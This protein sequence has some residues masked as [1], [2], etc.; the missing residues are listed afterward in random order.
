MLT[1]FHEL[2]G[3]WYAEKTQDGP[4]WINSFVI[5]PTIKKLG[6]GRIELKGFRLSG[7]ASDHIDYTPEQ[8]VYF[9]GLNPWN[10]LLPGIA[11][12]DVAL[13]PAR[14]SSY[15][16]HHVSG[17]LKSGGNRLHA[18]T[19][20]K[21][22]D[23]DTKE[24][25]RW[26]WRRIM[27]SITD[28]IIDIPI[29]SHGLKPVPVGDSI[30]DLDVT[31]LY[32]QARKQIAVAHKVPETFFSDSA[33]FAT[34]LEHFKRLYSVTLLPLS[35]RF[36][37]RLNRQYLWDLGDH[38]YVDRRE[39]ETVQAEEIAKA[40]PAMTLMQQ[41]KQ[42]WMEGI[43]SDLQL[44]DIVQRLW[45]WCGLGDSLLDDEGQNAIVVKPYE[46]E[47]ELA[48]EKQTEE[49]TEQPEAKD[50][51][52]K[53]KETESE[54]TEEAEE[55][56]LLGTVGGITGYMQIAKSVQLGEIPYEA[57]AESLMLFFKVDPET[58]YR[59]LGAPPENA[60]PDAQEEPSTTQNEEIDDE[61]IDNTGE[62]L[63]AEMIEE[64]AKLV[65][66]LTKTPKANFEPECL[67]S[68]I[69]GAAKRLRVELDDDLWK[70]Y[71]E[72]A[73]LKA[74]DMRMGEFKLE[75]ALNQLFKKYLDQIAR[76]IYEGRSVDSLVNDLEKKC[77]EEFADLSR[78]SIQK[79]VKDIAKDV[80]ITIDAA[81]MEKTLSKWL[82]KYAYSRS[83]YFNQTTRDVVSQAIKDWKEL[84]RS[85]LAQGE[86]KISEALSQKDVVEL[87]GPRGMSPA[88]AHTIAVTE[89]T[90][91]SF[92]ADQKAKELADEYG[93]KTKTIW[94]TMGDDRV[95]EDICEKLSGTEADEDGLWVHPVE[96]NRF[97]GPAHI[98]C[99]CYPL[100]TV[101]GQK[102]AA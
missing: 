43:L 8:M 87:L 42:Q 22:I 61:P 15:L 85:T 101:V 71:G 95:T 64:T 78:E 74:V 52:P 37:Q 91:M 32:D 57:A 40:T 77:A 3:A 5:E 56:K 2:S 96:G 81:G 27:H 94:V 48:D 73:L 49:K 75:R 79:M 35:F 82:D 39:M 9:K 30:K 102:Q 11:S 19:S 66:K 69:V 44:A 68:A 55:V 50:D 16:T 36:A 62:R 21:A 45:S 26:N 29:L 93:L 41:A 97:R 59:L 70:M 12:S 34:A 31:G 92:A 58:A 86:E 63:K 99:R 53:E 60:P 28:W 14:M 88:R 24:E 72:R 83:K 67:D 100:T 65:R 46:L 17:Y 20:D 98:G 38:L 89:T 47:E 4:E 18:L 54:V 13:Y 76:A 10:D 25:M 33:N 51:K 84:K 6:N 90:N 7:S 1:S 23:P 80:G